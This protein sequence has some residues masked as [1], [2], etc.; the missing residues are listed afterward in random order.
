M[1][2]N[3]D[4]WLKAAVVGSL[5]G[6]SEIVLGSFLH[7]L[8][9]PF[10]GNLLTAIGIVLMISG[11][12]IWPERGLI[13]RAGLICA[14]LKSLSPSPV[15]LG[16]MIS[17][18]MQASLMEA[19]VG[20][21]RGSWA[22]YL[23]GGGLAMGWN[24]F[25][26]ILSTL[27]LYGSPVI[28]LYQQLVT[29][30]FQQTGLQMSGYW[31]PILFL[32]GLFVLFGMLAAVAGLVISR[33]A[34]RNNHR[35]SPPALG[36]KQVLPV[37]EEFRREKWPLLLPV[38]YL[39]FLVLGLYSLRNLPLALSV[40]LLA[41]YF[42]LVWM[43]DHRLIYRFGKKKGF[44]IGLAVMIL[45][46]GLLLGPPA[47]ERL[48]SIE[49]L[50]IGAEMGMRA[51]YVIAGF[52]ILSKGLRNPS[53]LKWAENRHL[54]PFF[55]AV[56]IAFQTTPLMIDTIPGKQAWR[57]PGRVLTNMVR[58]MEHALDFMRTREQ[59]FGM[60]FVI[61][62]QKASGK[63]TLAARVTNILKTSGIKVSGILAPG[64]I[65]NGLRSGYWVKDAATGKKM[66]LCR[67]ASQ[68]NAS[69]PGPYSFDPKALAFGKE[70]L[71]LPAWQ[72]TGVGPAREQLIIIDE[73]GP[74]E[75]NGLGWAS[76]ISELQGLYRGPM[77]WVV[78]ESLVEQIVEK[79]PPARL[80]VFPADRTEAR[81]ISRIILNHMEH[82]PLQ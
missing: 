31:A 45:L 64:L 13:L 74:F 52:G 82:N 66:V 59:G 48:I 27:V 1:G 8:R 63:T 19:A 53:L 81:E 2:K 7:N 23:F 40:A 67:R 56:R 28:S 25:Y 21:G 3:R 6:A 35:W 60:V 55:S 75:L 9:I 16:P 20:V 37:A 32:G 69:L 61:S 57:R 72:G 18:F 4:I 22:G 65:E 39:A 46:S 70:A 44:W 51:L 15:I 42:F 38:G 77:I 10:S 79:W 50:R 78:R 14:A 62:G 5:W 33:A 71:S 26:R 24:L 29:Y 12:R 68:K 34:E 17:I 49:G 43:Y 11:H 36:G 73:L 47:S 76:A 58:S 30:L 54:E 80:R 41:A